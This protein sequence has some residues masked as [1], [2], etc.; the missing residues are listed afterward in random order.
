MNVL[1]LMDRSEDYDETDGNWT[2]TR[3]FEL[4]HDDTDGSFIISRRLDCPALGLSSQIPTELDMANPMVLSNLIQFAKKNYRSQ[5]Y[6]LIIWGHGTGWRY[7]N[8]NTAV[9]AVALDDKSGNFM[10][11]ADMGKAL[12]NQGLAVIG[13]DTCFGGVFENIYEL[14]EMAAYSVASPGI[15]PSAGWDYQKLLS[16]LE[17]GDFSSRS[18][19]LCMAQSASA[20]ITVFDN[21]KLEDAMNALEAFSQGLAQSIVDMSSQTRVFNQLMSIK[22]YVYTQFPCDRYLDIP[23]LAAFY[24]TQ[25]ERQLVQ[26]AQNL[27]EKISALTVA[28][29]SQNASG[30]GINFI[31]MTSPGVTALS[32]SRDYIKDDNLSDQCAFIKESQ[33]WVPTKDRESD[34]LLNKLFYRC[35]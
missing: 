27:K 30:V 29:G 7:S 8:S 2:D 11:I 15:T 13:F 33:W 1:V 3:L 4:E 20:G 14:K 28:A 18:I 9:R 22:S 17:A 10:S 21:T 12:R 19:A 6:A 16:S 31:P 25:G 24:S 35:Y 5:Q 26:E 34:S 23:S 32:H